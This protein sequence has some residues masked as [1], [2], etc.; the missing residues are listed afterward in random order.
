MNGLSAIK[1]ITVG[2]TSINTTELSDVRIYP[3][4]AKDVL[5]VDL[6]TQANATIRIMNVQGQEMFTRKLSGQN[7]ML[8][9]SNLSRGLYFVQ[10]EMDGKRICKKLVKE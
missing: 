1:S 4:P 5:H 8:D 7:N 3:N 6:G 2:A 10:M 9:I